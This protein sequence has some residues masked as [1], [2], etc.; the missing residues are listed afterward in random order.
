MGNI[1]N[2]QILKNSKGSHEDLLFEI[3]KLGIQKSLDTYYFVLAMESK[4]QPYQVKNAVVELVSFWNKKLTEM[5]NGTVI[6]L[7]I[8][9]SDQ[10]TGCLKVEKNNSLKLTY[11]YSMQEGHSINPMNP[12]YFYN[13]VT[14]FKPEQGKF[15]IVNQTAFKKCLTALIVKLEKV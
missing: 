10:Y 6:Y 15:L 1:I 4:K 5:P 9:F 14:D 3:P 13:T 8:D 12:I 7:P 2:I 11:G